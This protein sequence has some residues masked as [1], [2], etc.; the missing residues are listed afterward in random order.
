M[1]ESSLLTAPIKAE[2]TRL[3][4]LGDPAE[5]GGVIVSRSLRDLDVIQVPNLSSNPNRVRHSPAELQRI[6]QETPIQAHWHSHVNQPATPSQA[7]RV[8]CAASGVPWMICSYPSGVFQV[9]QPIAEEMPLLGRVFTHGVIDCYTLIK[10]YYKQVRKID[11]PDFYRP[12]DW[13]K[14]P[15]LDIY[16]KNLNEAGF[17]EIKFDLKDVRQHDIF[18]MTIRSKDPNHGAVYL[19]DGMMMHHFQDCLSQRLFYSQYWQHRTSLIA[20]YGV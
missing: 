18:L 11:L 6:D 16:R 10:D 14:T 19:G 20:R 1:N 13:W 3:A 2:M 4:G 17:S 7:D 8:S 12:D 9:I 15:G 5:V